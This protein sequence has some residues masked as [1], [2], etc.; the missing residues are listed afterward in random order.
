M[1][2]ILEVTSR[3]ESER[4]IMLHPEL[5]GTAIEILVEEGDAVGAGQVLAR[6]DRRDEALALR[7]A[8]VGLQEANDSQTMAGLAVEEAIQQVANLERAAEQAARDYGRDLKLSEGREVESPLSVQALEAKK[9]DSENAQHAKAQAEIDLRRKRLDLEG[10][11]TRIARAQVAKE[12]AELTLSKKDLRAPFD[13]VISSRKIREGDSIGP[14]TEAF[15]L[16]DTNNL[17]TV[18]SRP[19]EELALFGAAGTQFKD[20]GGDA[21]S[22]RLAITATTEAF[23]GLEF[24]GWVERISPTI[25]ADSGQFRV[26][27]RIAPNP[28]ANLLPGMLLRMRIVTERHADALV[29]PKRA[30][31]REGDRRYVLAVDEGPD[32][33]SLPLRR[34]E[35][36]EGFGNLEML[37]VRPLIAD[38]LPEGTRIVLVGSR[39]LKDDGRVRIENLDEPGADMDKDMPA[40][41]E[42]PKASESEATA[43]ITEQ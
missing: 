33:K 17:R 6:M 32:P 20:D 36:L 21:G 14:A 22:G 26:I 4:E 13:G 23:P 41:E 31:R 8:T 7:D 24:K 35:V 25:D 34:V 39:D 12:R 37:E 42:E 38:E 3:L 40:V 1:R 16:T 10:S 11:K 18:F 15:S 19:Q 9:L 30:I 2:N 27:A 29:V 43:A 5:S 28:E